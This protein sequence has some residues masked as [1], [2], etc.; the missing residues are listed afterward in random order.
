MGSKKKKKKVYGKYIHL[1]I[2]LLVYSLIHL[3]TFYMLDT[4]PALWDTVMEKVNG[5]YPQG[6]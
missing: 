4:V 1:F 5:T 3:A 6:V 2:Y